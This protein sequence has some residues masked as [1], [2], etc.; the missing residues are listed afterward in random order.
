MAQGKPRHTLHHLRE[1]S[2]KR[3]VESEKAVERSFHEGRLFLSLAAGLLLV[4]FLLVAQWRGAASAT[5]ELERQSDQSL[6]III[7]ELTAENA[8]L[9]SEVLRLQLR[10]LESERDEV[11]RVELLNEA[12]KELNALRLM[13]GLEVAV[14]P[15]IVISVEDPDRVLLPQDFVALVHELR[16]AGAEA[17]AV[18][19]RRVTAASGFTGQDGTVEHDG[20]ELTRGYKVVALGSASDLEQALTLPGGLVSTLSTFPGVTVQIEQGDSFLAPAASAP[21]HDIGRPVEGS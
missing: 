20:I 16:S 11:D 13:A 21:D 8:S 4:G 19:G 14:G 7:Q 15:G 3:L 10:V 18:N 6:G 17:I 1:E 9:R 12:A 5:S 2:W